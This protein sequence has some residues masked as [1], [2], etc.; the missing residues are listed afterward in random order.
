MMVL[1][2]ETKSLIESLADVDPYNTTSQRYL[3]NTIAY[4][5]S[6]NPDLAPQLIRNAQEN[7]GLRELVR[8]LYSRLLSECGKDEL[9]DFAR[10]LE[11]YDIVVDER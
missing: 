9:G 1:D 5:L 8:D 3:A 2:E 7:H 10:R 11:H 6:L 4:E